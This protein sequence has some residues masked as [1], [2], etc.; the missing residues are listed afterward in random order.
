VSVFAE[1]AFERQIV[2][3]VKVMCHVSFRELISYFEQV[4]KYG[5]L[6]RWTRVI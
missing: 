4:R 3:G 5:F 6:C 2:S 1:D